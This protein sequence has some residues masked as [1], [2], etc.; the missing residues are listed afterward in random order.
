MSNTPFDRFKAL[1][2]DIFQFDTGDLDFGIYRILNAKR[3]IVETFID[4]ELQTVVDEA[5]SQY[6]VAKGDAASSGLEAAKAKVIAALSADAFDDGDLKPQYQGLP[7]AADYL[8]ELNAA[9]STAPAQSLKNKI[10]NDLL[11]F[12]ARYYDDGDF[13]PLRRAGRENT[14]HVPYNGEEVVLHWANKNQ[15]YIK[16]DDKLAAYKFAAGDYHVSLEVRAAQTE[17]NNNKGAKRFY[18]LAD[19]SAEG[20]AVD[21]EADTCTLHVYFVQKPLAGDAADAADAASDD[22]DTDD[23]PSDAGDETETRVAPKKKAT[24]EALNAQTYDAILARIRE[25]GL[26]AALSAPYSR[27][28]GETVSKTPPSTL[29]R[30][31]TQFTK[32][33][34]ADFFIHKN[35]SGFLSGELDGFIKTECLRLD[36]LLHVSDTDF[37]LQRARARA[38]KQV[39]DKIIALLASVE[40]FQKD[41]F[42]KRKFVTRTDYVFTLDRVPADLH[43]AVLANAAQQAEWRTLYAMDALLEADRLLGADGISPA[44]LANEPYRRLPIDTRHFDAG[45]VAALLSSVDELDA[46]TD[47]VLFN[48]ENFQALNLMQETYRERVKCIYID[49]PYNTGGDGFLYKDAYQHSSWLSMMADRLSM[50]KSF[51]STDGLI[52]VSCDENELSDLQLTMEMLFSSDNYVATLVWEGGRKNDSRL[53]SISHDYITCFAANKD[54]VSKQGDWK[55]RK[56]GIDEIYRKAKSVLSTA[57][58][59]YFAASKLLKEWFDGLPDNQPAKRSKQYNAIDKRGVYFPSDISWPGGGGPRYDVINERTGK[60]VPVPKRGWMYPSAARMQEAISDDLVHFSEDE[61]QVPNSKAYLKDNEYQILNSV[62]YQDGRAATK[63]LRDIFG[64]DIFPNPKDENVLQKQVLSAGRNGLVLDFFAGSGTT[65][66]A[67]INLNRAAEADGT[68][69]RRKY[70]LCE[71]GTY[72]DTVLLPRLKKAAFASQW[73]NGTPASRDAV[74]QTIRYH[75]LEQYE[76]TLNNLELRPEGESQKALE[77]FGEDY[78]LRYMLPFD[79]AGSVPLVNMERLADPFTYALQIKDGDGFRRQTVDLPETFSFLLGLQVKKVRRFHDGAGDA[80]REYRAVF[81]SDR[82]QKTVAHIWRKASDLVSDA[83]ALTRDAAFITGTVLPALGDTAC[84]R[85]YINGAFAGIDR[86]ENCEPE[87]FRL[88]F[89]PVGA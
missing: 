44:V 66:H 50:A 3:K 28:S 74:S 36:E 78:L 55:I 58:G 43:A 53:V 85:V 51:L 84:D 27:K 12:F 11:T 9:A 8:R 24:Q 87:L 79:T 54:Y 22:T 67:V 30:H 6:A 38:T 1:L 49:P 32:K 89:A 59:D 31:L 64:Y 71:M 73:K 18:T 5:F 56:E 81:G 17:A 42:E 65:G 23:T 20:Y 37:A 86:A 7:V 63:R 39:G 29:L 83:E 14:Y 19:G 33:N 62:F 2:S 13:L 41:L 48:S 34:T 52:F 4:H 77:L 76:D 88:M 82:N 68:D 70:V 61:N 47:G 46:L 45:F 57:K 72:F 80:A 60:I 16:T 35:L 15:Y 40:D 25:P 21:Y 75:T 10:Y 69:N 26:R